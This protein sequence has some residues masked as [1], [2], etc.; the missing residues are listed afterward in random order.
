MSGQNSAPQPSSELLRQHAI[1][2]KHML[3]RGVVTQLYPMSMASGSGSFDNTYTASKRSRDMKTVKELISEIKNHRN[4]NIDAGFDP[5]KITQVTNPK[6]KKAGKDIKHDDLPLSGYAS[7]ADYFYFYGRLDGS[8]SD[9][10][11]MTLGESLMDHKFVKTSVR[12]KDGSDLG[13]FYKEIYSMGL[14]PRLSRSTFADAENYEDELVLFNSLN[15]PIAWIYLVMETDSTTEFEFKAVLP[16]GND[17][18]PRF[19]E[20]FS[21]YF[22]AKAPT[23]EIVTITGVSNHGLQTKSETLTPDTVQTSPTAF[24][25]WMNG[26]EIQ[27]YFIEY[28]DSSANVMLLMGL[29]GTGKSSMIRT[30]VAKLG[31]KVLFCSSMAVASDPSFVSKLGEMVGKEGSDFDAIVIEDADVLIRPRDKGNMAL[32]EILNAT[33]GMT[34]KGN[35]KLIVTTNQLTTENIDPALLRPGRCFDV[36]EFG[37][38]THDEANAARESVKLPRLKF[39][40]SNRTLAEALSAHELATERVSSESEV[41]CVSPR[42]PLKN[43]A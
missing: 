30:A 39:S 19:M 35:Y 26:T 36:M 20:T 25:P 10:A 7:I 22:E 23:G 2:A 13:D 8:T 9:H 4:V 3:T 41:R 14:I 18:T 43:R 21:K 24:Y 29:P 15:L 33:S 5:T 28:L 16:I 42:F 37:T 34:T 31:L 40:G 17:I 38:L 12:L 6:G 11:R 27:D 32:S 1:S